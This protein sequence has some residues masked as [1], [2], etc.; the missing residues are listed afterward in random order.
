MEKLLLK[1]K[2]AAKMTSTSKNTIYNLVANGDLKA[3][4]LGRAIRIPVQA[5]KEWIE[6]NQ[7]V[8]E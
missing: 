8:E 7:R 3:I 6:T 2:E 1:P 5:L 4:R